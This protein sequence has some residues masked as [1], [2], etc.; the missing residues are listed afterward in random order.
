MDTP[1]I[2]LKDEEADFGQKQVPWWQYLLLY[3][4]ILFIIYATIFY[5]FVLRP[6]SSAIDQIITPV[7]NQSSE[8]TLMIVPT[9]NMERSEIL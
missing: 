4:T 5:L 6:Q 9:E 1:V 7:V 2:Y 3:I 8:V